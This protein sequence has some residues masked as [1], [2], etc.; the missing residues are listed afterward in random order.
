MSL[1]CKLGFHKW[2]DCKCSVCGK[3]RDQDHEWAGCKCGICNKTRDENHD[4]SKDCEKCAK[5]DKMQA[6]VHSWEGCKCLKCGKTRQEGH[7]WNGCICRLCGGI[8]KDGHEWDVTATFSLGE[9]VRCRHCRD[10][11]FRCKCGRTYCTLYL[12]NTRSA[13]QPYQSPED[14]AFLSKYALGIRSDDFDFKSN[15]AICRCGKSYSISEIETLRDLEIP[16]DKNRNPTDSNPETSTTVKVC[17]NA[18]D[19]DTNEWLKILYLILVEHVKVNGRSPTFYEDIG[20]RVLGARYSESIEHQATLLGA[21]RAMADADISAGRPP[22]AL[23]VVSDSSG[24]CMPDSSLVQF[25]EAR[26]VH[27]GGMETYVQMGRI[28]SYWQGKEI[29]FI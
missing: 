20:P 18:F 28:A 6:A 11:V 17:L 12:K 19:K 21:L 25:I 15:A 10:V 9:Y 27:C 22:I 4:Y 7:K 14:R 3:N 24:T 5:C 13:I 23:M 8:K 2:T 1:L 26:G 29:E 16:S